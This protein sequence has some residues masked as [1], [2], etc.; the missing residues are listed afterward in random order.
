MS[1]IEKNFSIKITL[2][3]P[4]KIEKLESLLLKKKYFENNL[5]W[6][7]VDCLK[8]GYLP[9][10]QKNIIDTEIT[11]FILEH[12]VSNIKT[13]SDYSLEIKEKY[14]HDKELYN[15][16]KNSLTD[17]KKYITEEKIIIKDLSRS[18]LSKAEKTI[19]K[20]IMNYNK[21]FS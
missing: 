15:E 21:K 10:E 5:D 11:N 2:K 4:K 17:L 7:D 13:T 20:I 9:I 12:K 19:Q 8:G 14:F 1:V 18:E 16:I 6:Y 3:H